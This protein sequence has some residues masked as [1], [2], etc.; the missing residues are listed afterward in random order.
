MFDTH[1]EIQKDKLDT[2]KLNLNGT[3]SLVKK[4]AQST[5]GKEGGHQTY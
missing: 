3:Y 1:L 2:E 4:S 5:A